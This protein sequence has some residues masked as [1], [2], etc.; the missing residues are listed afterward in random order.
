MFPRKFVQ[1]I[2]NKMLE[3]DLIIF[4]YPVYVLRAPAQVKSLLDNL[5]YN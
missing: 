4:A 3:S 1:P 5:A 2:W